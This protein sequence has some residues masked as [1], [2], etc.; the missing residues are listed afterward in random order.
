MLSSGPVMPSV[1]ASETEKGLSLPG[2]MQITMSLDGPREDRH[3][4]DRVPL[5]TG[6]VRGKKSL[7]PVHSDLL[8]LLDPTNPQVIWFT[9]CQHPGKGVH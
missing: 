4:R 2:R 9:D 5:R 1:R 3:R 7:C 6:S 8:A